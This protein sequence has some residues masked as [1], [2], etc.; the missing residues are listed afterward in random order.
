MKT[1][2]YSTVVGK[3]STST[4][5]I[6]NLPKPCFVN[7]YS[8]FCTAERENQCYAGLGY[9]FC[10]SRR[11]ESPTHKPEMPFEF[12]QVQSAYPKVTVDQFFKWYSNPKHMYHCIFCSTHFEGERPS[13]CGCGEYKGI[14]PCLQTGPDNNCQLDAGWEPE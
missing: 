7:E 13:V 11:V 8:H 2:K 3:L 1:P 5:S 10:T 4:P 14:E 12:F 6:Q 9:Y